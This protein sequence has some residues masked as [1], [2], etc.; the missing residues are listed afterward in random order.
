MEEIESENFGGNIMKLK[1]FVAGALSLCLVGGIMPFAN[2]IIP[3]ANAAESSEESEIAFDGDFVYAKY[4]DHAELIGHKKIGED[5]DAEI[6]L[7]DK[8]EGVPLTVVRS[9]LFANRDEIVSVKLPDTIT[10]IGEDV[11]AGCTNLSSINMP[12]EL[13]STGGFAFA[14][15]E[16]LKSISIPLGMRVIYE[17]V[18]ASS[19]I[20]SIKI[21]DG[22]EI[23]AYAAFGGCKNL[24]SVD[25]PASVNEISNFAFDG[26]LNLKSIAIANPD[27][28]I[29]D[30]M[31]TISNYDKTTLDSTF[32]DATYSEQKKYIED[33][34]IKTFTGTIYGYKNSTA[35]A[36]AE[37]YGYDFVGCSLGDINGDGAINA[38]DASS[39][40]VEYSSVATGKNS[41]FN[42]VQKGAADVNKDGAID[43]LDASVILSYYAYTATGG[44]G[45]L[46]DFLNK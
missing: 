33:N 36:Y 24:T 45:S 32:F 12:R 19:G 31:F 38:L 8:I 18:F 26:C 22:I 34:G 6:N 46:A 29:F 27:C 37:E 17:G 42:V 10:Y 39:V 14:S 35:Q 44:T 21:P 43:A 16:K 7:P 40:L 9:R 5:L 41:T 2:V 30:Y 28:E 1:R 4:S 15:C 13:K 11:F 25:I 20:N 23:I 3:A